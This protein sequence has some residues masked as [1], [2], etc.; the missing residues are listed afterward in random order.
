MI[1]IAHPESGATAFTLVEAN[2]VI[3]YSNTHRHDHRQQG[4]KRVHRPGQTRTVYIV[5]LCHLP[6]DYRI[7]DVLKT[8]KKLEGMTLGEFLGSSFNDRM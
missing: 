6:S 5:D 2:V 1:A 4:L 7:L 3:F 8:K